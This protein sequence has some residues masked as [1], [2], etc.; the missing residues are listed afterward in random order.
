MCM[1]RRKKNTFHILKKHLVVALGSAKRSCALKVMFENSS[2]S[3]STFGGWVVLQLRRALH[4]LG[5]Q[6]R[7]GELRGWRGAGSSFLPSSRAGG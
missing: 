5:F 6:Q 1:E 4:F 3:A 2:T 7:P